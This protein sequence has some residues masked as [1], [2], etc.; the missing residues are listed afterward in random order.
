VP[1][2]SDKPS[3]KVPLSISH[4]IGWEPV[5]IM[6]WLYATPTTPT[7][8]DVVIITGGVISMEIEKLLKSSPAPLDAF[9]VKLAVSTTVGVPDISP[10]EAE[11]EKFVGKL[12]LSNDQVIGKEPVAVSVS[13]Y[14]APIEPSGR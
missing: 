2:D 3:G 5:A 7:G 6:V 14:G 8:S 13:L 9:T 1:F 4:V 10:V 12:P 11:S